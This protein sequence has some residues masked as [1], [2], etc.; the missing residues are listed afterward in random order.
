MY[1]HVQTTVDQKEEKARTSLAN[2]S[3]SLFRLLRG[4]G[5][6]TEWEGGD[7]GRREGERKDL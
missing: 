4:E 3:L 6:G 2:L 1:V 5:D 7:K